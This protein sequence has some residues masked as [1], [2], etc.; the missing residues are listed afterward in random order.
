MLVRAESSAEATPCQ[1]H[2]T[3]AVQSQG[4]A[5]RHGPM[6]ASFRAHAWTPALSQ[7][8]PAPADP[9]ASSSASLLSG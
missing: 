3:A 8:G 2:T 4:V 9:L 1:G 6:R 5:T 7:R